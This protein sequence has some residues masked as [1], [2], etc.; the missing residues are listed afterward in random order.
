MA[1]VETSNLA[2]ILITRIH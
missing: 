2:R 1:K